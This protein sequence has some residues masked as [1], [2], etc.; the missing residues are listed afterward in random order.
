MTST[1][2]YIYSPVTQG[3]EVTQ[4][5]LEKSIKLDIELF[6]KGD[7]RDNKII[8]TE[9][10]AFEYVRRDGSV[11]SGLI[12]VFIVDRYRDRRM[13]SVLRLFQIIFGE[14]RGA[15]FYYD[16]KAYIRGGLIGLTEWDK[17]SQYYS[18]SSIKQVLQAVNYV[19]EKMEGYM[20]DYFHFMESGGMKKASDSLEDKEK[21]SSLD[22]EIKMSY[23]RLCTI[24]VDV[25][26]NHPAIYEDVRTLVYNFARRVKEIDP[27]AIERERQD[28]ESM[29]PQDMQKTL[30][31]LSSHRLAY[32][33]NEVLSEFSAACS[34]D[35]MVSVIPSNNVVVSAKHSRD[36]TSVDLADDN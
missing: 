34:I 23:Q 36:G 35:G 31:R 11:S 30:Q 18:D 3:S 10:V 2:V 22:D 32:D 1:G 14:T 21:L 20:K 28:R 15:Q 12:D 8:R 7:G 27:S 5:D 26:K 13:I 6:T 17:E 9:K 24:C 16:T 33:C 4:E 19:P 25:H 29:D